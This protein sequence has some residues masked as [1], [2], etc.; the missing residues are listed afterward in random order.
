[1]KG[2]EMDKTDMFIFSEL[3]SFKSN[4][5]YFNF[6]LIHSSQKF[7]VSASVIVLLQRVLTEYEML[8]KGI[9]WQ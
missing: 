2:N 1:M 7:S 8:W 9:L 5:I 6:D 3:S 4:T